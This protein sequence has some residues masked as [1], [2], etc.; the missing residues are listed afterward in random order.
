MGGGGGFRGI[1]SVILLWKF[2]K[3]DFSG[4]GGLD[5]RLPYRSAQNT[6]KFNDISLYVD[7]AFLHNS[8]NYLNDS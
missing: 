5:H 7:R 6:V 3:Y 4:G 1:F 2:E 8:R